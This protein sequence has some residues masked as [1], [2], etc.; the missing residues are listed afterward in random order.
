MYIPPHPPQ[1]ALS[2]REL[3]PDP[4]KGYEACIET[5]KWRKDWR[6]ALRTLNDMQK[7]GAHVGL[8]RGS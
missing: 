8:V 5:Y 7:Q 1:L 6:G 3:H 2:L 4:V